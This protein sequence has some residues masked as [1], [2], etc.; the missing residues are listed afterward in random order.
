MSAFHSP[1]A[2]GFAPAAPAS[3]RG[4]LPSPID[5]RLGLLLCLSAACSRRGRI[6]VMVRTADSLPP[7]R[8]GL[9]PRLAAHLTANGRG[10][11]RGPL[12]VT[13][14][15]LAPAGPRNLRLARSQYSCPTPYS[16]PTSRVPSWPVIAQAPVPRVIP[17][18]VHC[19]KGCKLTVM[20]ALDTGQLTRLNIVSLII[21]DNVA[22]SR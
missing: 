21:M 11:L 15:G 18:R 10:Q 1:Y 12:A 14:A 5:S 6:P 17:G 8:G 3:Q 19:H 2:G 22:L 20:Q 16:P 4:L 9:S 7:F 13:T